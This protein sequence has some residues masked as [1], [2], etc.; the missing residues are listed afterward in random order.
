MNELLNLSNDPKIELIEETKKSYKIKITG[1]KDKVKKSSFENKVLEF[2]SDMTQFVKEQ[3]E[4][5]N[6]VVDFMKEQKEFNKKQKEFNNSVVDF[7]KEQKEFNNSV[8]DFIKE[9][10]EFNKEQKEFNHKVDQRLSVLESFHK[11]D[12]RK[13]TNHKR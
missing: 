10:K 5:N 2:M 4:F 8:V 1:D 11:D 12:F 13:N 6:S 9:Q 3:K 7:M